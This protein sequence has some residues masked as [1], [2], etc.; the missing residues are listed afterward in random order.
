[1]NTANNSNLIPDE[2]TRYLKKYSLAD[3]HIEMNG[4]SSC[5][6]SVVIPAIMEYENARALLLSLSRNDAKYFGVT[7]IL[8]VV[9]NRASASDEIRNDNHRLMILLRNIIN[10]RT[11]VDELSD[12]VIS[13]G[14]KSGLVDASS[15]GFELPEKDG[16]VGLARKI[17]MDLSLSVFDYRTNVKNILVCLDADCTVDEN[18]L[19]A[20]YSAFQE[21]KF[22]AATVNFLHES[23]GDGEAAEA[24]TCYEIFLRYYVFGLKY[25]R[26]PYA[27]HTIGSTMVCDY[28]SYIKTEGMNKRKAAEDF[29]FMEKLA[30]TT[31]INRI[32]SAVVYPSSRGSWRVPFGT[33]QRVNRHLSRVRDEYQLYAPESFRILK[34]WL[35][36]FDKQTDS[37]ACFEDARKVSPALYDFLYSQNFE[38][39]FRKILSNSKTAGQLQRQK[40]SWFDGFRTL[41]LIHYLRDNGYNQ[42]N[43]FDA[44]DEL[45]RMCNLSISIH[46]DNPIPDLSVQK[47]Y[48]RQL[49][50][51]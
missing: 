21:E 44:L 42:V 23:A 4:G 41:K 22:S 36:I 46:R 16:G 6:M 51:V 11:G 40:R 20:I 24:I 8:F 28:E 32:N 47:E 17:G 25:A 45:F 27:F 1:M 43:T 48:L 14:L 38:D 50:T 34:E 39:D 37:S 7:L 35:E 31:F 49:R 10:Q 15:A 18:Y 2:V 13:S 33:G 26:S 29:Y 19:S 5:S 9:N 3:W 30:K 12:L